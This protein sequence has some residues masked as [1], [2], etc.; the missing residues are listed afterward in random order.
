MIGENSNEQ[1]QSLEDKGGGKVFSWRK[2][3]RFDT[4]RISEESV[5]EDVTTEDEILR[6]VSE[7]LTYNL[8]TLHEGEGSDRG[9][10]KTMKIEIEGYVRT[11]KDTGYKTVRHDCIIDTIEETKEDD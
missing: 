9:R 10:L 3:K 2:R 6:V 5:E 8:R 11:S 7:I 1:K 4:I